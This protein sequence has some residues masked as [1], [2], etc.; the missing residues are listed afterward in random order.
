M[1]NALSDAP[2]EPST[3]GHMHY[4]AYYADTCCHLLRLDA[5]LIRCTLLV[6]CGAHTLYTASVVHC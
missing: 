1:S 3:A 4:T 5:V 2:S 6:W